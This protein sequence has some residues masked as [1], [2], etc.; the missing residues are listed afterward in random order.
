[1]G[2]YKQGKDYLMSHRG[3]TQAE[4]GRPVPSFFKTEREKEITTRGCLHRL[5]LTFFAFL[6]FLGPIVISRGSKKVLFWRTVQE[7]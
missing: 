3:E 7:Q 5:C 6:L 4:Q 2:R 1:M